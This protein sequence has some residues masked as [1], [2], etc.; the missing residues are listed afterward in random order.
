MHPTPGVILTFD[1]G[2][3]D[4]R[5][6]D[7][8]LKGALDILE[9]ERIQAVF[10]VLGEEVQKAPAL[11]RLIAERGHILQSH[12]WSH[13]ELPKLPEAQLRE[14]LK[15][16][17]ELLFQVAGTRPNRLRPPFG[18]GW[19][20]A[21][22]PKLQKVAAELGLTLTGWDVDTNDWKAPRGLKAEQKF[23]PPRKDW[24]A[25]YT[26]RGRALDILMHV[27][28]DT[29][30]E[31]AAFIQG[32]RADGWEFRTYEDT[33]Q[34]PPTE[35][36][37]GAPS[38]RNARFAG[39]PDLLEVLAG[40][41]SLGQGSRGEGLKAVQQALLDMGF[42]LHGGADG[43][44]GRQSAKALQN[45]QV[46]ARS[47]FPEVKP[48]GV[49]E[50]ASLRALDA[51]APAPRQ[52]GQTDNLPVPRYDGTSVRVV[53]VKDEHRT[54]LF[55]AQGRLQGIFGNAVGTG[56]SP[57]DNGLKKVTGKLG[58]A[59]ARALGMKLWG[60]PVF[61]PRLIDLSWMD[62]SRSGEELHGTNAPT[63]LGEDVSHGC[64]R[65]DNAA[66]ITLYDALQVG[67]RVAIVPSV[68][69]AHLGPP[70]S[71]PQGSSDLPGAVAS[72]K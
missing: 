6:K 11:V 61:G 56:A 35:V 13:V 40:K 64:L 10:Y 47:A 24:K 45:F 43:F 7:V 31:L 30:K 20:G 51:L 23:S 44:Y 59:E 27:N 32:M 69:D 15:R 17:Q 38:L 12:A 57:T 68:R 63:Q 71:A 1:D 49:L 4:D 62:G 19:V 33:P 53:V 42:S 21:K 3:I 54:F 34:R 37:P 22:S 48:S 14:E 9:A 55:D 29:V 52:R 36:P 67:D 65:H 60:G 8:A 28:Q 2:P 41:R 66:I 18:A 58:L 16:T 46:H 5:G 25:L 50:A 26:K 72:R 39:L 70:P